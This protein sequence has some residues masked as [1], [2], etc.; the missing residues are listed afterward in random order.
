MMNRL[1]NDEARQVAANIAKLPEAVLAGEPPIFH[2]V[3]PAVAPHIQQG[4]LRALAI[5]SAKRSA[6]FPDVPTLA[7]AGVPGHDVGFWCGVLL[8]K[9]TPQ[10]IVVRLHDGIQKVLERPISRIAL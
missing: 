1:T 4:T 6:F 10:D 7:E 3:L 8:P 2:E 9:G 5:T